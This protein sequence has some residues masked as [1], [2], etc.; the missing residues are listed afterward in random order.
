MDDSIWVALIAA[1]ASILV[2]ASTFY[3]TKMHEREANLRNEKLNHYKVLFSSLSDLAVDGTDKSDAGKRFS[4]AVNTIA[5]A[6]PQNVINALMSFHNEVSSP[7]RN[8]ERHNELLKELLLAVRKDIG[9]AKGDDKNTFNFH[10]IGAT[11]VR[12][13]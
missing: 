6:A 11:K 7:N 2:A 12:V 5:L 10:L 1:C 8:I 9:L 3:F 13:P 4:L